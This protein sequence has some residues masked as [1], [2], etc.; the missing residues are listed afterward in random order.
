MSI[1][2]PD[3]APSLRWLCDEINKTAEEMGDFVE[4]VNFDPKLAMLPPDERWNEERM[5]ILDAMKSKYTALW[6]LAD[7]IY[8]EDSATII[9]GELRGAP[10]FN[11]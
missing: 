7:E 1:E 2:K 3:G 4:K 8:G 11:Q 5:A 9:E 6:S 10:E